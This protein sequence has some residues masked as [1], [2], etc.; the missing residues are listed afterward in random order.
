MN[1]KANVRE[2]KVDDIVIADLDSKKPFM[3]MAVIEIKAGCYG[4]RYLYPGLIW[5]KHIDI[6]FHLMPKASQKH[7][8]KLWWY[9]LKDLHDP[10]RFG[11]EI[12]ESFEKYWEPGYKPPE[13]VKNELGIMNQDADV[14]MVQAITGAVKSFPDRNGPQ[15]MLASL[16]TVAERL[17]KRHGI[18]ES[19]PNRL[20]Q[21]LKD[22]NLNFLN[23]FATFWKFKEELVKLGVDSRID[24]VLVAIA[25]LIEEATL[26][27]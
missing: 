24:E 18:T 15:S 20:V 6:P 7:Y 17:R 8:G 4:T 21:A 22:L 5:D 14:L 11:I 10:E 13:R 27:G 12:P 25:N 2:W 1:Y 3:L 26:D 19:S 23:S 9:E 16:E